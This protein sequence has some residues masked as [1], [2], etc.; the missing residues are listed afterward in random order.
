MEIAEV[1]AGDH[2]LLIGDVEED[3]ALVWVLDYNFIWVDAAG[4]EMTLKETMRH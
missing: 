3:G 1:R 4:R 2:N